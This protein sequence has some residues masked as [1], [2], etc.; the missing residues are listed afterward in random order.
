MPYDD[1]TLKL[2]YLAGI[3]D[4]EGYIGAKRRNPIGARQSPRYAIAVSVSMTDRQPIDML[5]ALSRCTAEIKPKKRGK[6]K[7]IYTFSVESGM[8]EELLYDVLPY[9]IVKK[10]QAELALQLADL[11]AQASKHQTKLVGVHSHGRKDRPG[12]TFRSYALSDEYLAKCE[13]LYN[14]M[15]CPVAKRAAMGL[16][17]R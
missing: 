13:A 12:A 15:V 6:Y 14:E 7:A 17:P 5:A 9:L 10:R 8:A 11:R 3:I 2:A 1:K 16:A 4:G